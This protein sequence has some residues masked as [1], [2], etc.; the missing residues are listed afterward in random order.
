MSQVIDM[1]LSAYCYLPTV[2]SL[3]VVIKGS[4]AR[5]IFSWI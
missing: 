1:S 5:F 3:T 4:Q 2:S